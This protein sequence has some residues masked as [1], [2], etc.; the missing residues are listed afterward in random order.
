MIKLKDLIL[1]RAILIGAVV[2]GGA[3]YIQTNNNQ[4]IPQQHQHI[5]SSVTTE[6]TAASAISPSLSPAASSHVS[7]TSA[8][9]AP[10]SSPTVA[11]IL[12]NRL[13]RPNL[14]QD[15]WF[16]HNH[17]STYTSF[18]HASWTLPV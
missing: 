6:G 9:T 7:G 2:I 12:C 10:I 8:V 5:D 4:T 13:Q 3:I 18:F 16:L 1:L 11:A 17:D 14:V 15:R